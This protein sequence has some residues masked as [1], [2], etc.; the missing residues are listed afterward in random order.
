MVRPAP[1]RPHPG[2]GRRACCR[3]PRTRLARLDDDGLVGGGDD[4]ALEGFGIDVSQR[5][6]RADRRRCLNLNCGRWKA[7]LTDEPASSASV[8]GWLGYPWGAPCAIKGTPPA[9]EVCPEGGGWTRVRPE[10]RNNQHGEPRRSLRRSRLPGH[11]AGNAS[12]HAASVRR[13]LTA[14]VRLESALRRHRRSAE[15]RSPH[16]AQRSVTRRRASIR[17]ARARRHRIPACER[18]RAQPVQHDFNGGLRHALA[19]CSASAV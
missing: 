7:H 10:N 4:L 8:R 11:A 15:R 17:P 12:E 16:G 5:R 2:T 19:R 14:S 6:N 13:T 9:R 18:R 3:A 1:W